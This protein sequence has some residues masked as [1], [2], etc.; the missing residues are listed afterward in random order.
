MGIELLTRP[1]GSTSRSNIAEVASPTVTAASQS[2]AASEAPIS[3]QKHNQNSNQKKNRS[4]SSIIKPNSSAKLLN[5]TI[6]SLSQLK[7]THAHLLRRN[8]LFHADHSLASLL[9]HYASLS[10]PFSA[11]S[12]AISAPKASLHLFN[13]AIR[14]LSKSGLSLRLYARM[15]SLAISPDNFTFPFVLNSCAAMGDLPAGAEIHSRLLRAGFAHHLPVAN[16]L[17]DMY[18]KCDQLPLAGRFFDEMPV[19]D[20]VSHNALLGAHARVG[21]DM[22]SARKL[23]D[24]MPDKNIISWNAMIV[25]YVNAG[26]LASA[27]AI[28]NAI[29]CRNLVSWSVMIV[30]YCKKGL[31]DAA[32]ELFDE[33]PQQNL[34][35][36]TVMISGYMQDR[37]AKEALA[38]FN[39]MQRCGVEPDSA[40]MTCVVS[41]ISQ[42]GST[43]LGRWVGAYIHQKHI[44]KNVRLLTALI[45]MYAKCGEVERALGLFDEIPSP[46]A[47]SYTALINGLASNG[48]GGEALKL[49]ERMRGEGIRPD[50]ITFV[51]VL[52]ACGHSGLVED[53]LRYWRSMVEEYGIKPCSDHYACVVDMLGRAGRL[54]EAYEM[55][56]RMPELV[57]SHVG[58]LGAILAACRSYGDVEMGKIVAGDLFVMEPQNTGNYILLSSIYAEKGL[59]S[60]ADRVR[61]MMRGRAVEKLPGSSWV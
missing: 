32:R 43:E 52:S 34:V 13:R 60:E 4:F 23:F 9:S 38:L 19:T 2:Q 1:L 48:H 44:Q 37:R 42:L 11:F 26:N 21:E 46:D 41:A 31:V 29:P 55:I 54:G 35:S 33:M 15:P 25:G 22:L 51:G 28:F 7:K 6:S 5:Q 10:S 14:A 8:L 27:R 12:V 24:Q 40:T 58:A 36:W 50:P 20:L 17:I 59:W 3:P 30:G 56:S 57:G 45:D 39:D 49:F 16:A 18:G 53:G 61:K 47:H